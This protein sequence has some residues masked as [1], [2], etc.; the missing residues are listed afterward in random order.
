MS[1]TKRAIDARRFDPKEKCI[2][3]DGEVPGF[4]CRTFESG[5]KSFILDYRAA[6]GRKKR[7]TLGRYGVLT[8]DEARKR[9]R[10][11]LN[12]V[13]GGGDPLEE[14]KAKREAVTVREMGALYIERHAKPHKKSW[15]DDER[16]LEAKVYP[17]FGNRPLASITRAD[18]LKLHNDIGHAAPYEANRTIALIG[19]LWNVAEEHG[20]VPDGAP[21]PARRLNKF[22]ETSRDRWVT[23]EEMP[24]LMRALRSEPDE[25]VRTYFLLLLLLGTRKQELLGAKWEQIDFT[26]RELRI[27][28]NKA[29]RPLVLPLCDEAVS[30]LRSLPRMLGNPFL[31][32]SPVAHGL[33]MRD[34]KGQWLRIRETTEMDLWTAANPARAAELRKGAERDGR[35]NIEPRYRAL[36]L[37]ELKQGAPLFDVSIHD[38]RRTVGSWLATHGVSLITIGRI[39]NHAEQGVTSVYARLAE[40]SLRVAL[41]DHARRILAVWER[42]A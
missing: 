31:F 30:C 38:L 36:L 25:Y 41:E 16:R 42:A 17:A 18:V 8:P 28:E 7:L 15:R 11:A 35:E 20:L 40:S 5:V 24:A 6:N 22:R 21:N 1:L 23:E 29:S 9:A 12:A 19:K 13:S 2:L 33:P 10:K 32:P 37:A 39:L 14:R 3:W 34:V 4:G 27:E 26:R